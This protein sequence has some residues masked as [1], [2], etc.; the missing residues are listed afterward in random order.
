MFVGGRFVSTG[1]G[2]DTSA[3]GWELKV[4][5][6]QLHHGQTVRDLQHRVHRGQRGRV[7]ADGSA[8]DFPYGYESYHLDPD[9]AAQ[10]ARRGPK[11]KKGIRVCEG[12]ARWV[13]EVFAWFVAGRSIGGMARELSR[14][15]VPKGRR[16]S[17]G[18]HG[19]QCR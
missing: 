3:P 8:G 7:E 5:V 16:A 4:Q 17:T 12:E 9:W 2:I 6:L 19:I 15:D 10:L 1:E 18:R 13:R 14:L 11:P